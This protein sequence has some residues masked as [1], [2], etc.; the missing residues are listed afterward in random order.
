MLSE[1][2]NLFSRYFL[3][4]FLAIFWKNIGKTAIQELSGLWLDF[5]ASCYTMGV[6]AASGILHIRRWGVFVD[7]S[8]RRSQRWGLR[9]KCGSPSGP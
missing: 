3:E 9:A 4:H 7:S 6:D 1:F 5:G 8:G 2:V